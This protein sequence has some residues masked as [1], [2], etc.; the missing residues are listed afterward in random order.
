MSQNTAQPA[1]V[2][3]KVSTHRGRDVVDVDTDDV[4]GGADG[5]IADGVIANTDAAAGVDDADDADDADDDD[6]E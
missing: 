5:A 6:D 4:S 2:R 1:G 3:L